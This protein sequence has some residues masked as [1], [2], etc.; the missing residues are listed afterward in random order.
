MD[1]PIDNLL[2]TFI[3]MIE[4]GAPPWRQP[5]AN[6]AQGSLPLRADGQPFSGTNCWILAAVGASAGRASPYW[7]TFNQALGI[8][9]PVRKGERGQHVILFKVRAAEAAND[10]GEVETRALK[11]LKTYVV[12]NADQLEGL[13][14]FFRGA[15]AIDEDLRSRLRDEVLDAI[16]AEIVLGGDRAYYA[17]A[18]DR[19]HL[20]PPEAFISADEF[21]ST[22]AHEL[23]HWAGGAARLN[24][25]FGKRFGDQDY[26][27]E[28]LI[29]EIAAAQL[30]L[31]LRTRPQTLSSHASY[32][33]GWAKMLKARPGA[34]IE[35]SGHAQRAVDFLLQFS[36]PAAASLAA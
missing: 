14:D 25:E 24:R 20:P 34:L 29:A 1:R 2:Q 30:G 11:Y 17:R 23:A 6:G 21:Q 15:P 16:P 36:R 18:T 7:F 13:P 10:D 33:A 22:K 9:A 28:E 12:F 26:A 27:F 5:W 31:H 3:S 32:L 8:E 19:V 4:A 35:A